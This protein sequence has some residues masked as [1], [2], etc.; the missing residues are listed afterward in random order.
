MTPIRTTRAA[1]LLASR[2]DRAV[3]IGEPLDSIVRVDP[4]TVVHEA[5]ALGNPDARDVVAENP[6]DDRCVGILLASGVV[7]VS[8]VQARAR[9]FACVAVALLGG[10]DA[11]AEV[12]AAGA[13]TLNAA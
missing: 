3:G 13:V 7:L 1:P 10:R 11:V 8:G 9:K 2:L 5:D 12:P 4:Q 6:G